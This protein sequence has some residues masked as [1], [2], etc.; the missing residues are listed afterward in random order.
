VLRQG[1]GKPCSYG[2]FCEELD[3]RQSLA[4]AR[5][6]N[7]FTSG[8]DQPFVKTKYEATYKK[9]LEA[10]VWNMSHQGIDADWAE[11]FSKVLSEF[12]GLTKLNLTSN[13]LGDNGAA[14]LAN[15]LEVNTSLTELDLEHTGIGKDGAA[16]LAKALKVNK[17]LKQLNLSG[18]QIETEGA[19]VLAEALKENSSLVMLDLRINGIDPC[20]VFLEKAAVGGVLRLDDLN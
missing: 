8:K 10:P 18:N 13:E 12:R 9:L 2:R 6:V 1:R 19:Y 11:A 14:A 3:K 4:S 15:A 5:K 17:T 7:L 20:D 16:A